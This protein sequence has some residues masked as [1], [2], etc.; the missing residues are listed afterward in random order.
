MKTKRTEQ[1]EGTVGELW[2]IG[3]NSNVLMY[4][5]SCYRVRYKARKS[6]TTMLFL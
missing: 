4:R 3:N 1:S 6:D 2:V 5:L